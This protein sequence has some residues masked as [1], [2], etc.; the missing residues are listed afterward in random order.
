MSTKNNTAKSYAEEGLEQVAHE[1]AQ[2]EANV[3]SNDNN[4]NGGKEEEEFQQVGGLEPIA[5]Y[6]RTSAPKKAPKQPYK[7]LEKG[8]TITGTYERSFKTGKFKNATYVIRLEDGS[9]S[10]ISGTGSLTK[11]MD[12]LAEGSRVKITYDGM[13]PI[14]GGE[15]EGTDAHV[16][17]VFGNKLRQA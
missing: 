8:Q 15:W 9:L 2:A 13:R 7:V 17:T 14:A 6:Y 3:G 16:F 4:T 12:K 5:F 11:A 10:G 1:Q